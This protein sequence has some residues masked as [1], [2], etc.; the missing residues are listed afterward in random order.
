MFGDVKCDESF[1]EL[2]KNLSSAPI[3]IF[4]DPSYGIM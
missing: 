1:Q 4:I 2:K 3:L